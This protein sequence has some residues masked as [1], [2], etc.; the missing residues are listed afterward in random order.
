MTNA[1]QCYDLYKYMSRGHKR[2]RKKNLAFLSP[3]AVLKGKLELVASVGVLEYARKL[4]YKEHQDHLADRVI[5]FLL[6]FMPRCSVPQ[7]LFS[8]L[9]AYG[10]FL[11]KCSEGNCVLPPPTRIH[12]HTEAPWQNDKEVPSNHNGCGAAKSLQHPRTR[13]KKKKKNKIEVWV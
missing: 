5:V 1:H 11:P 12:P 3:I 4:I 9:L 6:N 2:I 10:C 8:L 7:D 13:A